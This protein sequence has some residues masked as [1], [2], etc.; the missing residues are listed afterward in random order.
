[1]DAAHA[2]RAARRRALLSQRELAAQAGVSLRTVAA[3]EAGRTSPSW[4]TM[5]ALLAAVGLEPVL[6]PRLPGPCEHL[7]RFLR[8]STSE[9]L[10]LSLGGTYQPAR[11]RRLPAWVQL[12]RL[13]RSRRPVLLEGLDA[14]GVWVPGVLSGPPL[15]VAVPAADGVDAE[16]LHGLRVR[17]LASLPGGCVPAAVVG[18]RVF[19]PSPELLALDPDE[20]QERT[21]LMETKAYGNGPLQRPAG[22]S[23]R[24]WRLDAPVS[25]RQWMRE[26]RY[27]GVE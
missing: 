23:S 6:G 18:G 4:R 5:S 3:I 2:V 27:P 16:Q 11:D 17:E 9:R 14:V 10:Y 25:L 12:S 7:A 26:H 20:G 13:A 24:A 22:L 1:M 8:Y 15:K 19:V 21:R